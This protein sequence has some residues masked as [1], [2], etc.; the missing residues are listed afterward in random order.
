MQEKAKSEGAT[1]IG[2]PRKWIVEEQGEGKEKRERV[3]LTRKNLD[4]ILSSDEDQA[5]EKKVSI[6]PRQRSFKRR[7]KQEFTNELT[8]DQLVRK[9]YSRL[10]KAVCH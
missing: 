5:T 4:D 7:A 8:P 9:I 2:S 1:P 10:S 3:G 6:R